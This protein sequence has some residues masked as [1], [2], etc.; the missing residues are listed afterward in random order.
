MRFDNII[1]YHV[2][3][4]G[5]RCL[6][7]EGGAWLNPWPFSLRYTPRWFSLY[8]RQGGLGLT[9]DPKVSFGDLNSGLQIGFNYGPVNLSK[10]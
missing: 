7:P 3:V 4:Q 1:L 8:R 5:I 9:M 10:A 2:I 6:S